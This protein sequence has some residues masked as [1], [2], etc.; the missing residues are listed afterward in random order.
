MVEFY[1]PDKLYKGGSRNNSLINK[2]MIFRVLGVLLF[3][4][5]AMFLLCAAVSLCYGEQDYQYFL[6]TIL[7]NTLVGGVLLICSRGAE[8]RLTRR[9]GYCIVTFT[10]FLFTLFGMLPFYFSG[11]IPS[12]TDAFFETMSGFTTTGATIL[13]DIESLSHGL[14]FWRSLTQW[15][16]G[17]GI[18]FFTIAVLP[19]FGGGTIQLF[20]AEAIGVTH[21]KTHPRIDVMAKWLWMIYAILTIAETVLLMIGG[22]SFFD[23]VCHS[24]ST[25]ATGG[26][27]TKQ[28][29]VA[30]WNSPFIEY[31]IAIFMILSGINF[32]LYFMCLKGKGKRLFQDD[33]FRWFMKSVSILTLVIT[34][35]LVFQNHYDWEKAFRRALFQVATAHTSCGFA[36]DDYNLWPSFTWMLLIFAML[37]GGCTGSTSGGIKNMRL[38]ILARNIKNEFKRML[39]PRAVLP[40]RV[41]RQVISPS[42]IASV[43]T[44]FVFY[45]FC[46]LAGWILLMFFG[47]GIIE[48]M[49]T[50]ISSL[51]NVGPGLGAFGPAFSWAALPD[52]AKWILSF[53]M[54]IGRLELFAVL[55]LFYS[56]FWERR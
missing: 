34:F 35:A 41:N 27:S 8:N 3:I 31:V 46:I 44:F 26:Y 39:H 54:L 12:V 11:G 40:V 36:T 32:S 23:A 30:Y 56:G 4:E 42:I 7:L 49:S 19:I 24:F 9:D 47:V 6:Y 2:K 29:S 33:E 25:T 22:M 52:A 13:D 48:A 15:I 10:W 55:L 5:S 21:D 50:V 37:S 53:L 38:M 16:G 51:G 17:L 1:N 43:N 18:V 45:L 14:L 28:A 20:S